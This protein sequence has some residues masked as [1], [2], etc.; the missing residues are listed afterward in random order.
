MNKNPRPIRF[1]K[2]EVGSKYSI[3]AEPS[4]DIRK[5]NDSTVWYKDAEA[6]STD[7]GNPDRCAILMPED[8]VLPLSRPRRSK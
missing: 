2:L 5:S 6:Y 4:R 8:L 3:F 1:A 7:V